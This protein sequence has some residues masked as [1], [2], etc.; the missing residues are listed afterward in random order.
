[1]A[2]WNVADH[3]GRVRNFIR[4]LRSD[5]D[6]DEAAA[7]LK[8]LAEKGNLLRE[9]RSKALGQG[10]FEL[11][12]KQVRIFYVFRPGRRIVLLDGLVKKQSQ[13]PKDT[14]DALRVLQNEVK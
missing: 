14:L 10:L 3:G 8:L 13:I 4:G 11:R 9:P 5:R 7:L 2:G 1:M 6:F 12:G